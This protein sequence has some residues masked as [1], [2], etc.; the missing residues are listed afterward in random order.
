MRT[1]KKVSPKRNEIIRTMAGDIKQGNASLDAFAVRLKEPTK[2][3]VCSREG[4]NMVKLSYQDGNEHFLG[5][6]CARYVV[7]QVNSDIP[8]EVVGS[9]S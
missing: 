5:K 8:S 1:N 7:D 4:R 9:L 2:C 6:T 3:G